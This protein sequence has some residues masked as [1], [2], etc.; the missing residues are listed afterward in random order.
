MFDCT[1][2]SLLHLLSLMSACWSHPN[3][4]RRRWQHPPPSRLRLG[5]FFL[6]W[7]T[8]LYPWQQLL[9]YRVRQMIYREEVRND[10]RAQLRD[11][12]YTMLLW[13]RLLFYHTY[14]M[15]SPLKKKNTFRLVF[16]SFRI[17]WII[18]VRIRITF[19]AKHDVKID[20]CNPS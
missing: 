8:A 10:K 11:L 17:F 14:C 13:R 19:S 18:W 1:V 3:R 20:P 16:D 6:F 15:P 4:T 5:C 2:T 9:S 7:S 12:L